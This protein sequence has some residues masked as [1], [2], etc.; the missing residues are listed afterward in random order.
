MGWI[1]KLLSGCGA[2]SDPAAEFGTIEK[3]RFARGV[4][5]VICIHE[6]ATKTAEELLR[7]RMMAVF[8]EGE[9]LLMAVRK[10]KVEDVPGRSQVKITLEIMEGNFPR[11]GVIACIGVINDRDVCFS[12]HPWS[13]EAKEQGALFLSVSYTINTQVEGET[14]V[15]N[16]DEAYDREQDEG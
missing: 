12:K 2:R 15:R 3:I 16:M 8:D 10:A 5:A 9:P 1:E 11:S 13:R 7:Y 6:L 14:S 4:E